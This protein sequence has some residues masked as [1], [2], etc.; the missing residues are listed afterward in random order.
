[1]TRGRR[2]GRENK[3][4][5]CTQCGQSVDTVGAVASHRNHCPRCLWSKHLDVHP[6]DREASCGGMMEPI[7]V[8]VK[9]KGEWSIVHRCR[10]CGSLDANTVAGDDN[11]LVLISL[12]LRPLAQPPFPLHILPFN[13]EGSCLR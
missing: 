6:G 11:E 3:P 2:V 1:M 9:Q 13:E 10:R 5:V 12:A 7:A 4:F 8:S